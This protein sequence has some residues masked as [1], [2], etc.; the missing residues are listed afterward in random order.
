MI[1]NNNRFADRLAALQG[2]RLLG[3]LCFKETLEG[4]EARAMGEHEQDS[5][6]RGLGRHE[7]GH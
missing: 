1:I 5:R 2:L 3:E 4:G 6:C 7:L